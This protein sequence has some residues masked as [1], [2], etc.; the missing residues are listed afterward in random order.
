MA[1]RRTAAATVAGVTVLAILGAAVLAR[2]GQVISLTQFWERLNTAQGLA[3]TGQERPSAPAMDAVRTALG[4]PV[5]ADLSG[6]VVELAPDPL[7][8]SL[9]GD[10]RSDFRSALARIDALR[11]AVNGVTGAAPI[12]R[13]RLHTTLATAYAGIDMRG[14]SLLARVRA[15]LGGALFW[16]L[17][18]LFSYRGPSSIVTWVLAGLA[19]AALA[20]AFAR[21]G[22][23]RELRIGLVPER[24]VARGTGPRRLDWLAEAERS[25]GAGDPA[26]AVRSLY[27]AMLVALQA[28]GIIEDAP[29]VTAGEARLAVSAARPSLGP[30]V[31]RATTVFERVAYGGLTPGAEDV[32][33]LRQ[34]ERSVRSP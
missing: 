30:L 34:A 10:S 6:T 23:A 15:W 9:K 31:G 8:S 4:L 24:S 29:S 3:R 22:L 17:D 20:F 18:H 2:A 12:D 5:A 14:P 25:L 7:L 33:V 26:S 13:G 11:S 21:S 19:L 28:R 1:R 27:R 16:V 32:D